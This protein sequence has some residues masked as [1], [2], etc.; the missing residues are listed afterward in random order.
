MLTIDKH[1]RLCFPFEIERK[2]FNIDAKMMKEAS[3]T[4]PHLDYIA[5]ILM[6]VGFA[7][8]NF[9]LARVCNDGELFCHFNS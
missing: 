7:S 1:S 5:N 9:I 8:M 2:K 3:G 4:E 6:L